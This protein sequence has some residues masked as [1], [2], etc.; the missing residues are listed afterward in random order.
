M[1]IYT[2][3]KHGSDPMNIELNLTQSA[4]AP[5]PRQSFGQTHTAE[6]WPAQREEQ[7]DRTV[8]VS[9]ASGGPP[10]TSESDNNS[11]SLPPQ[12]LLIR[13]LAKLVQDVPDALNV[14]A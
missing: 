7:E 5:Y 2:L 10:Q 13:S 14:M 6:Y 9:E 4:V 8:G 1:S 12:L 3:G 11:E